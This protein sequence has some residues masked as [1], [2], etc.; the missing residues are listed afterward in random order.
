MK[1]L[2][3]MPAASI[4]GV[5][6]AAVGRAVAGSSSAVWNAVRFESG[7]KMLA[8]VTMRSAG[9]AGGSRAANMPTA[10]IPT[11]LP[12]SWVSIRYPVSF[13]T[14]VMA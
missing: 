14:W 13:H 4:S 5:V 1:V 8:L 2:A 9:I 10:I 6:A 11:L 12:R 7:R 3:P